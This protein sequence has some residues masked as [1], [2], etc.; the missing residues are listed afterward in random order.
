MS[1][2]SDNMVKV[3]EGWPN[4]ETSKEIHISEQEDKEIEWIDWKQAGRILGYKSKQSVK[5]WVNENNWRCKRLTGNG[6]KVLLVKITREQARTETFN[7]LVIGRGFTGVKNLPV[8]FTPYLPLITE[9]DKERKALHK[10][11]SRKTWFMS[12]L[13]ILLIVII[14]LGVGSYYFL[15]PKYKNYL[16]EQKSSYQQRVA[17][18]QERYNNLQQSYND[19]SSKYVLELERLRQEINRLK[20]KE[21]KEQ[22]GGKNE[23]A[24]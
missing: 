24:N 8:N 16:K 20:A 11:N 7:Q 22:E 23:K 6:K 21:K 13:S 10:S 2:E 15:W 4:E 14:G 9:L 1:K 17:E 12:I 3:W 19:L 5:K 18:L